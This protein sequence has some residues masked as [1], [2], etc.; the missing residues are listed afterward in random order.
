MKPMNGLNEQGVEALEARGIDPELADRLG[1]VS[2]VPER[3]DD[4]RSWLAF[5]HSRGDGTHWQFRTLTGGKQFRSSSD[6]AQHRTFFNEAVIRD[7]TLGRM[8]LVITEGQMDCLAV[9][10]AGYQRTVSVPDGAPS[11]ASGS[12]DSGKAKY[13]YLDH[14]LATIGELDAVVLATDD[15]DPGR[16]L[17]ADLSAR[18]GTARC[19]FVTWPKG[20][21]DA[22]DV[23]VRHGAEA[24]LTTIVEARWCNIDGFY[25][26]IADIPA[27]PQEAPRK[28]G[29]AG[30]DLI[31]RPRRGDLTVLVG[32]PGAGKTTLINQIVIAL[33]ETGWITTF[34]S[35]EVYPN[36]N[37]AN[38]LRQTYLGYA[39]RSATDVTRADAWIDDHVSWIVPD[40]DTSPTFDWLFERMRAGVLRDNASLLVIDPWNQVDH[41]VRPADITM[42]EYAG[43]MLRRLSQFARDYRAHV[44]LAV[45]PAKMPRDKEGKVPMPTGYDIADSAHFVN[46]PDSGLTVYRKAGQLTKIGCWKCRY[47]G[48]IGKLGVGSFSFDPM[49]TRFFHAPQEGDSL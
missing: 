37:H 9:L 22:N 45:H 10:Q 39:P 41:T 7:R 18:I 5:P 6:T 3:G 49:S 12:S 28:S 34:A 26:C 27:M 15:D 32:T 2:A 20:C 14:Y 1:V 29:I 30:L 46:R 40:R 13:A 17:R 44:L 33:G 16:A 36:P 47:E 11:G 21:K 23:L 48:E 24:L 25:S 42:T 35:F 38:L 43:V 4:Q 8:A 31:W 19:K